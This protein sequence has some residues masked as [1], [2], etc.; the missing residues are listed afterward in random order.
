MEITVLSCRL[1]VII[2][3]IRGVVHLE[4]DAHNAGS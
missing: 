4:G 1:R 3:L 2:K